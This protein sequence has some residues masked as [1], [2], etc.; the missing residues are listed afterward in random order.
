MQS[1]INPP[2]LPFS[3]MNLRYSFDCEAS[4]FR[5]GYTLFQTR[6]DEERKPIIFLSHQLNNAKYNFIDSK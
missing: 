6:Q 1:S 5:I 3:V 2:V 4:V